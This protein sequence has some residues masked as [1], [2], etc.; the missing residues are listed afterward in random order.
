MG[1]GF[2]TKDM[3]NKKDHNPTF[4][5]LRPIWRADDDPSQK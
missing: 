2:P 4:A 5:A 1:T 3:R